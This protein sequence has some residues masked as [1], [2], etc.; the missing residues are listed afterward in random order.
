MSQLAFQRAFT[1]IEMIV[2]IV[3]T[4]I[5]GGVIAVFLRWPVQN[6]IDS[7]GRAEL[8]DIADTALRRI[9]REVHLA[10][11][12]SVRIS[13]S[14]RALEFVPTKAGGRYLSGEDGT[15]GNHL[16]FSDS[17]KL[18][19]KVVGAMPTARQAIVAG[20]FIVVNNLGDGYAPADVYAAAPQQNR[21]QVASVDQA[22][23]IVTLAANP[24]AL[25]VPSMAH[26]LHR[27]LVAGQPVTFVCAGNTL[28][29]YA[30]YGFST[31]Q[32]E[33]PAGGSS[34]ILA[35]S[36]ALNGA[37]NADCTFTYSAA[38]TTRSG[39][40]GVSLKLARS[41]SSDGPIALVKQIHVDNTP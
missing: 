5:I 32:V 12:N 41:G 17:S 37:G 18:A 16:D 34:A 33:I 11:P 30:N 38:G 24:F 26:P 22:G 20:D 27:F 31:A 4:G 3:I 29:R 36:V 1:L 6:Y 19:F 2:V 8:T 35:T 15:T 23:G 28:Y 40:V 14:G 9:E 7:A 21:A 25:Q 13:A 39:L 10:V